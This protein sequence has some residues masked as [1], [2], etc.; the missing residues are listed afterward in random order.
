M[1][2]NIEHEIVHD[3]QT[4]NEL[5][6]KGE[7]NQ[8]LTNSLLVAEKFGKRHANV[9]RVIENQILANSKM[10]SL[11]VSSTYVDEQ[12]KERSMYIMNRDGFTLLAMSFT[13]KKAL[14]FKLDY[15]NAFNKMEAII[16]DKM[17]QLNA[18]HEQRLLKLEQVV[19]SHLNYTIRNRVMTEVQSDDEVERAANSYI[20]PE[21]EKIKSL[22]RQYAET[23]GYIIHQAWIRIYNVFCQK[24]HKTLPELKKKASESWLDA[25]ERKGKIQYLL[26]AAMEVNNV[27][28]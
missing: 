6:F 12:E 22:V 24:I 11:Y 16:K 14:D 10:S 2:N 17:I 7:N 28:H 25:I 18:E 27:I 3:E 19:Y 8:V 20:S 21:R 4:Q 26:E 15:I 5:V 13:G 9:I 1:T 23:N